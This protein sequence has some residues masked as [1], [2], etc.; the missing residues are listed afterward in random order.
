MQRDE[1]LGTWSSQ[2]AGELRLMRDGSFS[3]TNIPV[4]A[5]TDWVVAD[6]DDGVTDL[7]GHWMFAEEPLPLGDAA[8]VMLSFDSEH[9][10]RDGSFFT[11]FPSLKSTAGGLSLQLD[12][13]EL[14]WDLDDQ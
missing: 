4:T 11:W 12:S 7:S 8:D 2:S 6:Q 1:L 10:G 9:R 3:I 5:L 14:R 13:I